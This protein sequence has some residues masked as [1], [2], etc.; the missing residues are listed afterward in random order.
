TTSSG[1]GG[2]AF[3]TTSGAYQTSASG[4]SAAFVAKVN[5]NGTSK[6][7]A[8]LLA[9]SSGSFGFGIG[10][11][12]DGLATVTGSTPSSDFPTANALSGTSYVS[13]ADAYVTQF[14]S[15]GTGLVYSSFL[16]AGTGYGAAVDPDSTVYVTG[17]TTGSFP[18]TTGAFQTTLNGSSD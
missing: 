16:G 12:P 15:G 4:S 13:G 7:Y 2:I 9:G 5:S 8:S 3:P 10:V 17:Q 1:M 14:N 18:A 6:V 11:T